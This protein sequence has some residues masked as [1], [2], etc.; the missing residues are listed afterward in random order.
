MR[1]T[2]GI[3]VLNW[4]GGEQTVACIESLRR[5]EYADK[6]IVLV[7]NHSS[8]A[9]RIALQNRYSD[10]ADVRCC[11]LDEN[12]GY[13]GG[14]NAGV[15]AALSNGAEL[16]VIA[17]Q[18]VTFESGALAEMVAATADSGIGIVG[19]KVVDS[20]DPGRVLSVGER[21]E[22]PL[23]CLPRTWL[24]Y[25]R[26][27]GGRYDVGAVLGCVVLLTRRCLQAVRGFDDGFFAYYEEIDL[28]LRARREGFRIVCVPQAVVRHDGMR[29]F[30]AGFTGL[31]AE[32]KARNLI[33][34]IRRWARPLDYLLL[35][36]TYILLV[37]SSM[38]LYA[39][40]GRGDLVAAMLRGVAAGL[41]GREGK[42]Q[43]GVRAT[44]VNEHE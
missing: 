36:P 24:R 43:S 38:G 13:A 21:V 32:L 44:A 4:N 33:R 6:F 31:S 35:V 7:D 17:T 5:Q 9:E 22:I 41:Q 40:R 34:L 28:C 39:L 37:A 1:S 27:G 20:G 10:A 25:R 14:N 30:A 12:R 29:G 11:W 18:D 15:A 26:A 23:L 19:P 3:V 2:V 8:S 42:P 16:I